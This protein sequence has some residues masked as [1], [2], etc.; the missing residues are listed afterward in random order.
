L[1]GA[2]FEAGRRT[3]SSHVYSEHNTALDAA[4]EHSLVLLRLILLVL[5]LLSI[6][7]LGRS[8]L[9]SILRALL[10]ATVVHCPE[11]K[12][13]DRHHSFGALPSYQDETH[14]SH[15]LAGRSRNRRTY[16]T[17][18]PGLGYQWWSRSLQ[19]L[20]WIFERTLIL[21]LWQGMAPRPRIKARIMRSQKRSNA[22]R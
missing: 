18:G 21:R 13:T 11:K 20:G 9:Q 8:F 1:H 10:R 15:G 3:A 12:T 5:L 6:V 14:T 2:G 17:L 4:K 19:W 16:R 22:S 7:E